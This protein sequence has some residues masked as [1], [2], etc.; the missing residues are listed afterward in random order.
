[1]AAAYT[2]RR[3]LAR[4]ASPPPADGQPPRRFLTLRGQQLTL[5]N[6]RGPW[7]PSGAAGGAGVFAVVWSTRGGDWWAPLH[8]F[9]PA[10]QL[11]LIEACRWLDRA[12]GYPGAW[13]DGRSER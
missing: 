11:R 9:A 12:A 10:D 2:P 8:D 1:M 4:P 3:A 7:R 6:V 5:D 13:P